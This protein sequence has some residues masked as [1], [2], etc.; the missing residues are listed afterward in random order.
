MHL[1]KYDAA[2]V[3]VGYERR[4]STLARHV[5]N[6][7]ER[8]VAVEFDGHRTPVF[9]ENQAFY[10]DAGWSLSC[11][12]GKDFELMAVEFFECQRG[13]H[14][15]VDVSS[16]TRWRIASVIAALAELDGDADL[17]VD[18]LYL[19]AEY[20][21]PPDAPAAVLKLRPASTFFAGSLDADGATTCVIGLGYEPEKAA[22][23]IE[24]L[25]PSEVVAFV[26]LDRSSD[27]RKK[28]E[29][30]NRG[31]LDGK[32]LAERIDY[33]VHDPYAAFV[34]V[35]Q[36]VADLV[37][38]GVRPALVPM[39]PKIFAVICMLVGARHED[40]VSVWRASFRG[41]ELPYDHVASGEVFGLRVTIGDGPSP[42]APE[43]T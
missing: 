10:R 6:R 41:A 12:W 36:L 3:S 42:I 21:D 22:G 34:L 24:T 14:V 9:L 40:D 37:A 11:D 30:A 1:E 4:S 27:Y 20:T 29:N 15:L 33:N 28:V 5:A 19:P 13:S 32:M 26:P 2:L 17:T 18:L 35:D 43:A 8:A 25:E 7:P 31:L 23:T 16:M 38:D 39:G